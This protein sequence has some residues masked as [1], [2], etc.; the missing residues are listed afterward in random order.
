MT[1]LDNVNCGLFV[2]LKVVL[3]MGIYRNGG[4]Y[5]IC[6]NKK[7]LEHQRDALRQN[8]QAQ[9]WKVEVAKL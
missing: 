4:S 6:L 1:Q 9:D 7:W 5:G 3:N 2:M 8:I